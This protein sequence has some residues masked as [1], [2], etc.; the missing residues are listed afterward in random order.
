MPVL[1]YPSFS[2]EFFTED[3]WPR[4][5]AVTTTGGRTTHPVVYASRALFPQEA[6]SSTT[7]LETIAVVWPSHTF[8]LICMAT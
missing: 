4:S 7:E 6:N 3:G 5:S 2:K 1:A 8:T